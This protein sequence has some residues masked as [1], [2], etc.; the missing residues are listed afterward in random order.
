MGGSEQ[1]LNLS[2]G[3][4]VTAVLVFLIL[5]FVPAPYGRHARSGWGP[6]L[7]NRLGWILMEAPASLVFF[8]VYLTGPHH[9]SLTPLLLLAL[10]QIHYVHRSFI[11]PWSLKT[12]G[13]RSPWLTVAMAV[14]FNSINAYVN[15]R[16]ISAIGDYPATWLTTPAF[17]IG[18][19]VF[20]IGFVINKQADAILRG[21]RKDPNDG[22]YTIPHGGLYRFVSC[23]NYLG[24]LLEWTGW[25]IATSALPGL[26]FAI[27]TAANL[28]PRARAHHAWYRKQFDDYP[29]ERRAL[30]PFLW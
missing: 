30:I 10:W 12:Q 7:P 6:T 20:V 19:S 22:G 25:A 26:A 9:A 23:P 2:A 17:L 5:I 3:I 28:V 13:K 4:I 11:Y 27:F 16:W 8:G 1:V 14:L 29:P 24:E 21:L 15:A 18:A